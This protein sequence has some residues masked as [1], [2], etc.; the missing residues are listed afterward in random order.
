MFLK[1]Y[2]NNPNEKHIQQVV[3]VLK[4]GGIIIYPTDTVYALGCDLKNPKALDKL[5]K[6]KGI[7]LEKANFSII[8]YDLSHLSDYTKPIENWA[9][10]LLKRKLPGA[11][12][13]ILEANNI[14]PRLFKSKK[15]TLGI[16]VPNNQ[17]IRE[18]VRVLDSPIV[19]TSL[20][21][22]DDVIEYTTDPE[23]IFE[24]YQHEV[25][26]VIDGGFG[27]NIGSTVVDL[28][29]GEIE[30]IREGKGDLDF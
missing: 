4:R 12:T 21:D 17:I 9:F 27:G 30:L 6:L 29:N 2:E 25:D 28:S 8:C 11:Y 23:L 16:R 7:K 13:F 18:I 1:L 10:K 19:S 14:V 3:D 20:K 22:D 24:K 26:L 5:A 15:K